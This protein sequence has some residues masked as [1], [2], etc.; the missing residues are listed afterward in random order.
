MSILD[1]LLASLEASIR[2]IV[3]AGVAAASGF[4]LAREI[5]KTGAEFKAL[6]VGALYAGL[7]AAVAFTVALLRK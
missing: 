5:P 1:K 4:L 6:L 3:L 7:R 2:D